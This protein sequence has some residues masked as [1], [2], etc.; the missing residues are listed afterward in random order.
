[1]KTSMLAT[2]VTSVS[3]M[4]AAL[5]RCE[6]AELR[7]ISIAD[8]GSG[9]ANDWPAYGADEQ[10]YFKEIG[11]KVDYV[12]TQSSSAVMQQLAAG[13]VDMGSGG[14]ADPLRAIDKG[15][16]ITLLRVEAGPAPYAVFAKP[17]IHSFAELKGKTIM[18]GG[19]KDIT[20]TYFERMAAPEGLTRGSY[21]MVFAG[22]TS[23]R[24]AALVSGS[25]DATILNPP[26]LFKAQDEKFSE[27][28]GASDFDKGLP[29]TGYSVRL[30]WAKSHKDL[31]GKFLAAY[32]KG[33]D[34]LYD[35]ANRE[36]AVNLLVKRLSVSH[37][38]AEKTYDMYMKLKVFD[39]NATIKKADLQNLINVLKGQGDIDGSP[40]FSRFYKPDLVGQ[41]N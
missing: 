24:F 21:D 10:G 16:P 25:I 22:A 8:V 33:V 31:I 20:R 35:P 9:S 40:D 34:W 32:A 19:I 4:A 41:P 37:D 1:M 28:Q 6:A 15:A 14:L 30:D 27:L 12:A 29:F 18:L 11:V 3:L 5:P 17:A 36:D 2:L 39:R 7:S 38:D 26:F 23:A 13:S